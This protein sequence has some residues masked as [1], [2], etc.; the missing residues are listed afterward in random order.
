[1]E[2]P[3]RWRVGG[4]HLEAHLLLPLL[5]RHQSRVLSNHGTYFAVSYLDGSAYAKASENDCVAL[6]SWF[7][8]DLKT[9]STVQWQIPRM[10]IN[11]HGG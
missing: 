11:Q 1:M 10:A 8:M 5:R 7:A 3:S 6:F 9:G 2:R 4:G